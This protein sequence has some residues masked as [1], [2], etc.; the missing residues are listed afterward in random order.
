MY[1]ENNILNNENQTEE[2]IEETKKE[3]ID[4]PI[5]DLSDAMSEEDADEAPYNESSMDGTSVEDE[6]NAELIYYKKQYEALKKKNKRKVIFIIVVVLL[7]ISLLSVAAIYGFKFY[8]S[9]LT[10]KDYKIET[11]KSIESAVDTTETGTGTVTE[12]V[13]ECMPSIVSIT[14]KGVTEVSTFFGNYLQEITGSGSGI[15]IG[16]N[17]EELLIVSN[18]HVVADSNELSVVFSSSEAENP[19]SEDGT[20]PAAISAKLKGYDEEKDLAVISVDL[21]D[22]PDDVL[23]TMKIA[24]IGDSTKLKA[25]EQVVAIGNALGYGQS[26][27]TGIISALN[28]EVKMQNASGS[29]VSNKFI[30]TDAAINPG[31][32][33]G[34]LLNM[35]GELIGINSVKIA[36]SGVEGMGYA[37]PITDVEEIINNLMVMETRD[38]VDKDEQG[39]LGITG[40]DVTSEIANAYD[41]PVGIYVKEVESDSAAEKGGIATGNIIKKFDGTT[42]KTMTELKKRLSYYKAG[43]TVTVTLMVMDGNEYKEKDVTVVLGKLPDELKEQENREKKPDMSDLFGY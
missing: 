31:N 1:D 41:I 29:E 42:V 43:E 16:Q 33:G 40:Q 14:N 15:I 21:K 19:T 23:S 34:A 13:E 5:I 37:I 4:V 8:K 35:R 18:Y 3:P 17:E 36:S 28:R 2:P 12:I 25:G 11:T 26:V 7:F 20:N 32:S 22:I 30:Q 27:T 6:Q 10:R 39:F 38:V 24:K 9:Q